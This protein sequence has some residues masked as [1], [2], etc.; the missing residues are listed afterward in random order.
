MNLIDFGRNSSTAGSVRV[1]V[2]EAF[3]PLLTEKHNIGEWFVFH[4]IRT[5]MRGLRAE[6]AIRGRPRGSKEMSRVHM[7]ISQ[8]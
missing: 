4:F 5:W 8:I 3:D 1:S 7:R 6:A 2:L